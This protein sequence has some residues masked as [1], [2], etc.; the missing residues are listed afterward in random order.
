MKLDSGK[1]RVLNDF[2]AHDSTLAFIARIL[3][4]CP[5][6]LCGIPLCSDRPGSS[7]SVAL[8]CHWLVPP[9]YAYSIA[10]FLLNC[11]TQNEQ[12]CQKVFV[13]EAEIWDILFFLLQLTG[14]CD[15]IE[16]VVVSLPDG[17]RARLF[18]LGG[19]WQNIQGSLVKCLNIRRFIY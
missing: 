8:L 9:C 14:K 12:S 6:F 1:R 7:K 15:I 5:V 10:H 19:M 13:Q 4:R 3:C 17:S 2:E 16:D 11:N 18:C